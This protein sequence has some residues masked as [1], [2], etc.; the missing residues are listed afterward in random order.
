MTP[1]Q[2]LPQL[3]IP[4]PFRCRTRPTTNRNVKL[5]EKP[6]MKL[7]IEYHRIESIRGTLRPTRSASQP[8]AT[9]PIS[10]NQSDC[11]GH[12]CGL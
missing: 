8:D 11:E 9:A 5:G 12:N 4:R 7:Q 3:D 1:L 2:D 6:A 10:R